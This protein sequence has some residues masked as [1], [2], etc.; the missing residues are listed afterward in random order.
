[1]RR[2][3]SPP[4]LAASADQITPRPGPGDPDT[5]ISVLRDAVADIACTMH[6]GVKDIAWEMQEDRKEN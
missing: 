2:T 5:G 6:E 3:P 4:K 1:M